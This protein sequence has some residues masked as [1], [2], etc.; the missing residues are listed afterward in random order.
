MSTLFVGGYADG[1]WRDT[2]HLSKFHEVDSPGT[3]PFTSRREAYEL[4][5]WQVGFH[6]VELYAL[7]GLSPSD[8]LK[9]LLAGYRNTDSAPDAPNDL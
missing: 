5:H 6:K 3:E 1:T 4:M 7:M 8:V 2:P 9:K